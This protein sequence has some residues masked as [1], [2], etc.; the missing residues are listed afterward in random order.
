MN[1]KGCGRGVI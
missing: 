1:W